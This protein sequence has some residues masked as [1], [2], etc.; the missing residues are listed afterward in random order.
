[1]IKETSTEGDSIMSIDRLQEKIRKGKNVLMVD[2]TLCTSALPPE[3]ANSSADRTEKLGQYGKELLSGLKG[4]VPAVRFRM[5]PFALM[6][7][8]GL[9]LLQ[10]LLKTAASM[11]F[12]TV[13]DLPLL[14]SQSDAALAAQSVF[15]D[16]PLYPC[17]GVVVS[18]YPG[19]DVLKPFL[20]YCTEEKKDMF[21]L[22]RSSNRSASEMQD[23]LSGS[24]LVHAAGAE[25][26]ERLGVDCMG[27]CGFSRV[28]ILASACAPE[29]LRTLRARYPKMFILAD[30][31]DY[32][33]GNGRGASGCVDRLGHGGAVCVGALVTESWKQSRDGNYV[34]TAQEAAN[35]INRNLLT[36]FRIL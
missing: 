17:D 28:G 9:A 29:S 16:A 6:G 3:I 7:A 25:L 24:R 23:L 8:E 10:R 34:Q 4:I 1:M 12:Y 20:P 5:S 35:R 11:H 36:Y 32:P 33:S 26:A 21:L 31:L 15:G 13:V 19:S 2:M 18:A 30:G 27:R 14:L 22:I